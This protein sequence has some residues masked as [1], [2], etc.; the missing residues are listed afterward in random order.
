[1]LL[2][3]NESRLILTVFF[4]GRDILLYMGRTE[5]CSINCRVFEHGAALEALSQ[6]DS[7]EAIH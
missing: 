1:M 6:E 2:S 3:T 4:D 5:F 7:V